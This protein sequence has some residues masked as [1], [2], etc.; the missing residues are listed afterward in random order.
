MVWRDL[1]AGGG[2]SVSPAP[3]EDAGQ[4]TLTGVVTISD[5][6]TITSGNV[7]MYQQQLWLFDDSVTVTVEDDSGLTYFFA[8]IQSNNDVV[9]FTAAENGNVRFNNMPMRSYTRRQGLAF[10]AIM[11]N[12]F[13]E[14]LNN[15]AGITVRENGL[16]EGSSI[17]DMNFGS[18]L[19]LEASTTDRTATLTAPFSG[20]ELTEPQRTFLSRLMRDPVTLGVQQTGF[21]FDV[22]SR[23]I[24][25]TDVGLGSELADLNARDTNEFVATD[26]GAGFAYLLFQ[27]STGSAV[28]RPMD[29]W[30]LVRTNSDRSSAELIEVLSN[31][32]EI[33]ITGESVNL[34]MSNFPVAYSAGDVI[35]VYTITGGETL[36]IDGMDINLSDAVTDTP[37]T[38]WRACTLSST[39]SAT[40]VATLPDGETLND[41]HDITV[42]WNSG[43]GVPVDGTNGNENRYVCSAGSL[44]PLTTSSVPSG[45]SVIID[46]LG[47]GADQF[48]VQIDS[49]A[50]TSGTLSIELININ[51]STVPAGFVITNVWVR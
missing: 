36:T 24:D 40:T 7:A 50:G 26:N 31:F 23:I 42:F 22:I 45:R 49:V 16:I 10:Y 8:Y 46:A 6:V 43:T 44:I 21:D 3:A 14:I 47:R 25:V 37:F 13:R 39:T 17:I 33:D 35:A 48:A 2:D 51:L 30:A 5:D 4:F 20:S 32:V 29:G 15:N 11:P 41:F 28:T 12:I 9:V 18:G 19:S 34:F 27:D 38:T 1:G